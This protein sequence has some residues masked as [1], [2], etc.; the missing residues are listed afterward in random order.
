MLVLSRKPGEQILVGSEIVITILSSSRGRTK[1]GVD[2]PDEVR[3]RRGEVVEHEQHR[4]GDNRTRD[5]S[6][7][8]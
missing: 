2:A 6:P 5:V 7:S 1:I 3:I 8:T 4:L